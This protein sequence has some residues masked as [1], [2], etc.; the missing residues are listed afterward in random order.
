MLTIPRCDQTPWRLVNQAL[1]PSIAGQATSVLPPPRSCLRKAWWCPA[2][3]MPAR[4][5]GCLPGACPAEPL[6]E[7]VLRPDRVTV[8]R[9]DHHAVQPGGQRHVVLGWA[10]EADVLVPA[11]DLKGILHAG[12]GFDVP[13]VAPA[14]C[15]VPPHLPSPAPHPHPHHP[16]PPP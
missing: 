3:R 1:P 12:H 11:R 7:L 15:P 14:R 9:A 8:G 6:S 13:L 5:T 10:G 2:N 16:L 4:P